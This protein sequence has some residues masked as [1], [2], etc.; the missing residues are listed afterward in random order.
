MRVVF[1]SPDFKSILETKTDISIAY[2]SYVIEDFIE[3]NF[4]F[5]RDMFIELNGNWGVYVEED[6]REDGGY[7]E[8]FNL[9]YPLI[10]IIK[11]Q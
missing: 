10:S 6:Y 2:L 5:S 3:N 1:I 8:D 11:V 9:Y 7:Q 4:S